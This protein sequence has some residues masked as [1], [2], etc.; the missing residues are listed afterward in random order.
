[1]VAGKAPVVAAL[2]GSN[3]RAGQTEKVLKHTSDIEPQGHEQTEQSPQFSINQPYYEG[4]QWRVELLFPQEAHHSHDGVECWALEILD[5]LE[6]RY[7]MQYACGDVC[8][9]P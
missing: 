6:H 1:M 9:R 7:T 5:T 2:E 3:G 8:I 4:N